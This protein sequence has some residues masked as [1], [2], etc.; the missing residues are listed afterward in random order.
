MA[1]TTTS[2]GRNANHDISR[3]E[4]RSRTSRWVL[5]LQMS[6]IFGDRG[7]P[8][9]DTVSLEAQTQ[10]MLTLSRKV[11]KCNSRC[12]SLTQSAFASWTHSAFC[13]GSH[14]TR[15]SWIRAVPFVV[16]MARRFTSNWYSAAYHVL[17]S[18]I[19]LRL[20][21]WWWFTTGRT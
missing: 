11:A 8:T 5:H 3:I 2:P 9:G 21:I 6:N 19:C 15:R 1:C 13:A 18:R 12:F 7:V 4:V 10:L 14:K 17:G 16:L 20:R